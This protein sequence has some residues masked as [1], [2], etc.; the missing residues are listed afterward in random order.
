MTALPLLLL[1]AATA[2]A[3]M[4]GGEDMARIQRIL[5]SPAA[6]KVVDELGLTV[7][8]MPQYDVMANIENVDI[9][10]LATQAGESGCLPA[11]VSFA[12]ST[13]DTVRNCI[14]DSYN[15]VKSN[16]LG[17]PQRPARRRWG[18]SLIEN[19]KARAQQ[20]AMT[21][22]QTC[23]LANLSL[24]ADGQLSQ[25]GVDAIVDGMTAPDD[26]KQHKK[27]LAQVCIAETPAAL[28]GAA[29]QQFQLRCLGEL[30]GL[31]C[32]LG[33]A[34]QTSPTL[35][36]AARE[37]AGK[38]LKKGL[39]PSA[40]ATIAHAACTAEDV[41]SLMRQRLTATAAGRRRRDTD[42]M[43]L[44]RHI[45]GLEGVERALGVGPTPR[46]CRPTLFRRCPPPPPKRQLTEQQV[47]EYIARAEAVV[48]PLDQV[49]AGV[50]QR[51]DSI[52][53]CF[54]GAMDT[55]N[56]DG[57]VN[58]DAF[59][60]MVAEFNGDDEETVAQLQ[61]TLTKVIDNCETE[62]LTGSA[63][64]FHAC[65]STGVAYACRVHELSSGAD[66]PAG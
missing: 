2:A 49:F 25:S 1:L 40:R 46:P 16:P 4:P 34:N 65:I 55:L 5:Q 31:D 24:T 36:L 33:V 13:R 11:G 64:E 47:D 37:S 44:L 8:E 41:S 54:L 21:L 28:S 18:R 57:S 42:A 15:A 53:A 50:P 17:R 7:P 39:R 27:Q 19:I 66:Q 45:G 51:A 35:E 30:N 6:R 32:A 3:M 63:H 43:M 12:D 22:M 26:F 9:N 23:L 56:D 29:R 61:A 59:R 48:G 20:R 14:R 52:T 58:V 60:A 10:Q 38:C 62:G